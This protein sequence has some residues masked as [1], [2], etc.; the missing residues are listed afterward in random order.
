M[1]RTSRNRFYTQL[2]VLLVAGFS[3]FRMAVMGRTGLGDSESYYWTWSQNLAMSYF[4]HPPMVAWLIRLFTDIGGDN[5]FMVR[6]PSV[7]L[8]IL[9]GWLFHRI[10]ME[11]FDDARVAFYSILTFNLVPVFGI[12][13]MQMVP[14][15]PS[16]VCYLAYALVLHRL[17]VAGGPGRQWYLLGAIM[18]VG[19]LGKYFAILLVPSVIILVA[20]VPEYRRW[21][22][23]PQPYM[24]ALI[25]LL[26]FSPVLIWNFS[27]DWPSFR[28]HLVER[29]G[30]A[31][32]SIKNLEHLVGGQLLYV[33]P[34]YLCGF[35]WAVWNAARRAF[36]GDR[37]Y[38][39]LAA[40]SAPTILFFYVACAWTNDS[41]PHWP[42][43]GYLTA[44]IAM[45]ALG[46]E[47]WDNATRK[48]ARRV[49]VFFVTATGMAVT[50]KP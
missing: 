40:F 20:S 25:A 36:K 4:D 14:D 41:E 38:A 33:T 39:T 18:G 43:F 5:S 16:A 3:A 23:R 17:L 9:M 21:F 2:S 30:S 13:A 47:K 1:T 31:G 27:N 10:S 15:I 49:K 8:F 44:I 29:H 24:M 7:L 37:N 35:L 22:A 42:A 6:L 11:M 28:F 48:T 19:L 46:L 45:S 50:K 26:L 34:L 12:G 32:F